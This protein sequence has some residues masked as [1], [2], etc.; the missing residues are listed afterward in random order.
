VV[1][2]VARHGPIV[3]PDMLPGDEGANINGPSLIRVPDWVPRPLGRYYLYF[4]HHKGSRIRLA[5]ADD[6]IGR[7]RVHQGGVL[8]LDECAFASGHIASPDV[9]IDEAEKSIVMYFHGPS[10]VQREQKS[11]VAV[12]EDG[13]HFAALPAILGP[14]YARVFFHG[15]Y[16]YGVFGPKDQRIYRS[17]AGLW[18]FEPGPMIFPRDN[19]IDPS[20]RHLAVQKLDGHL[21][22]YYTRQRDAPERILF[23]D[24]DL[25]AEWMSWAVGKGQELIR[26]A[27]IEEGTDQPILP[28]K[29]GIARRREHAL[30]DPAIYEEG[31]RIWL[32]YAIAGEQGIA[33]AEVQ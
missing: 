28:S 23:G 22:V 6:L 24:I 4:A 14:P 5:Y 27:T 9:H 13:L 33:L 2:L 10:V 32:L 25:T 20:A 8:S 21:R 19:G 26:P 12:S 18:R 11:F 3:T 31:G 29:G 30:R 7:W 16:R 15:G 1:T 17:K